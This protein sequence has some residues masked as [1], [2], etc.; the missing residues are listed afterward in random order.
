MINE[1]RA[2]A[3]ICAEP[4]MSEYILR[5]NTYTQTRIDIDTRRMQQ[6]SSSSIIIIVRH[7]TRERLRRAEKDDR[8]RRVSGIRCRILEANAR[9][10]DDL[11]AL[12]LVRVC[13]CV[14]NIL[15]QA[16]AGDAGGEPNNK[17]K[18]WRA[19]SLHQNIVVIEV[20]VKPKTGVLAHTRQN[21][22]TGSR[23]FSHA[24]PEDCGFRF[25]VR[26]KD[27]FFF[28]LEWSSSSW[29]DSVRQQSETG[30]LLLLLLSTLH[31]TAL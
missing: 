3:M 11:C 28:G 27:R 17:K 23:L 12:F 21:M 16:R 15:S 26:M 22:S 9:A 1:I 6:P 24:V 10:P 7:L 30:F 4:P 5:V 31:C 29:L 14:C 20:K 18:R 8:M 25:G 13:V 2:D 19:P